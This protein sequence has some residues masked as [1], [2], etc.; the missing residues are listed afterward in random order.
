MECKNKPRM[1]Y[2]QMF[3]SAVRYSLLASR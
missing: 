2:T 3:L 1:F